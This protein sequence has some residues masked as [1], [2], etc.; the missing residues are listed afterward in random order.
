MWKCD[1]ESRSL[2]EMPFWMFALG[3]KI[4]FCFQASGNSFNLCV[5]GMD[6]THD[7]L[8]LNGVGYEQRSALRGRARIAVYGQAFF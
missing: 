5:L 1:P 6:G 4:A 2:R 3:T 7:S 8:S